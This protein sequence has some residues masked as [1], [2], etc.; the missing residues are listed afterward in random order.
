M[1]AWFLLLVAANLAFFVWTQYIS[2]GTEGADPAPLSRQVAP[3]SLK[4]V[5][6][7]GFATPPGDAKTASAGAC[8]EWGSFSTSEAGRMATLLEP[9]A[10]GPRLAQHRSE[11]TAHWWVYLPPQGNRQAALRKVEEL[12]KLGV[13]EYF[14]LQEEGRWRWAVSLG[15]FRTEEAA[16]ARL[17]AV[18][19]DKVQGARVGERDTQV[20]R[21]WFRVADADT[22]LRNALKELAQGTP[23]TDVRDCPAAN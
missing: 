18:R 22:T 5:P 23:G 15:V 17:E 12:K 11:E 7:P 19:A 16:K 3:E 9:L 2:P 10:L 6:P 1:R 20:T 8:I 21:V 13:Q 14:V 4:L